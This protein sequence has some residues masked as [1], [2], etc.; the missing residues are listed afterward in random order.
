MIENRT[1]LNKLSKG[2][3]FCGLCNELV[4]IDEAEN[5]EYVKNKTSGEKWYHTSCIKRYR[6]QGV[7]RCGERNNFMERKV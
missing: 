7:E 4:T 3:C 5:V 2:F 1:L 6:T